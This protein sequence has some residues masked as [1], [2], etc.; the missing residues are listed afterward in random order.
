MQI[1]QH[2]INGTFEVIKQLTLQGKLVG[3]VTAVCT[4]TTQAWDERCIVFNGN[5]SSTRHVSMPPPF[6]LNHGA[7]ET[8]E[9]GRY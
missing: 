8:D 4:H 1:I 2:F 6:F 9:D 7:T 5:S 3:S